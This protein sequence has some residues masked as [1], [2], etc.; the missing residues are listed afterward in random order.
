ML[1]SFCSPL[2]HRFDAIWHFPDFV[3]IDVFSD[4]YKRCGISTPHFINYVD[5][6]QTIPR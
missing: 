2:P 5:K 6:I 1:I 4:L 3:E